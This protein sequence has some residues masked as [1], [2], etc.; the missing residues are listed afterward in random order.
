MAGSPVRLN[1]TRAPVRYH[2]HRPLEEQGWRPGPLPPPVQPLPCRR[3]RTHRQEA[4]GRERSGQTRRHAGVNT[5][6]LAAFGSGS[7]MA[8]ASKTTFLQYGAMASTAPWLSWP[9]PFP[10]TTTSAFSASPIRSSVCSSPTRSPNRCSQ[11]RSG[12][13]IKTGDAILTISAPA[14][15]APRPARY[16]APWYGPPPMT[17]TEPPS[18][19]C[20]FCFRA[21]MMV[22]SPGPVQIS[23]S[24]GIPMS[25][26]SE[27]LNLGPVEGADPVGPHPGGGGYLPPRSLPVKHLPSQCRWQEV[28]V[29]LL[30]SRS[31]AGHQRS[32]QLSRRPAQGSAGHRSTQTGGA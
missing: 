27:P 14:R 2:V 23:A 13:G 18:P 15:S 7:R 25:I 3:H 32:R 9:R 12:T 28:P 6:S 24:I 11:M 29:V 16:G 26:T 30:L 10:Q 31:R 22:R 19:L 20:R 17:S 1:L 21:G 8:S 4:G 5:D